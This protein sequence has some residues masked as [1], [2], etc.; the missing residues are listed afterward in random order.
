MERS[1]F[2][3]SKLCPKKFSAP[4][5][6]IFSSS[7][8]KI[9][10]PKKY[11]SG[12]FSNRPFSDFENRHF[13][14]LEMVIFFGSDFFV[15]KTFQ[16]LLKK[17]SGLDFFSGLRYFLICFRC[18]NVLSFGLWCFQSAPSTLTPPNQPKRFQQTINM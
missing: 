7:T 4:K 6:N 1:Q 12:N 13:R 15:S 10:F 2:F 5:K 17:K 9:F 8:K 16:M 18:K 14:N 11:F 3:T